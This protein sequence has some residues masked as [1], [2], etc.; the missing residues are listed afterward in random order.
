VTVTNLFCGRPMGHGRIHR[1]HLGTMTLIEGSTYPWVEPNEG[2]L[3]DVIPGWDWEQQF[4][5]CPRHGHLTIDMEGIRV[6]VLMGE[7]LP[8][9]I[10]LDR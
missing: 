10:I 5:E 4:I 9:E 3:C 7:E 6:G 2:I 8:T 1:K